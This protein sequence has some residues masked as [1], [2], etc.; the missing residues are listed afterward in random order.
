M[1]TEDMETP[2]KLQELQISTVQWKLIINT[3]ITEM[4]TAA[5]EP[6]VGKWVNVILNFFWPSPGKPNVFETIRAQIEE[7]VD[8]K[9]LEFELKLM[10]GDINGIQQDLEMYRNAKL[11]EK[12]ILLRAI[13]TQCNGAFSKIKISD[14]RHHL[15]PVMVTL[16]II[17]LTM[18]KE[19]SKFGKELYD[20]DN[21]EVWDKETKNEV[22]QYE[23]TLKLMYLEWKVWRNDKIM[24]FSRPSNTPP[25]PMGDSAQ[26]SVHDTLTN[27]KVLWQDWGNQTDVF[28]P[29]VFL[30]KQSWFSVSN[31]EYFS[32]YSKSFG[33]ITVYRPECTIWCKIFT[34]LIIMHQLVQHNSLC[35]KS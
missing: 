17:Q 10:Q 23:E 26:G 11:H 27:M 33:E 3:A 28:A 22:E 31:A 30:Q 19:R 29:E 2:Q 21:Q 7:L 1:E 15:V 32:I 18:L 6:V 8:T 35:S 9:I 25:M 14:H 12:G 4:F 16:G 13:L 34:S 20:E 5:G 24:T